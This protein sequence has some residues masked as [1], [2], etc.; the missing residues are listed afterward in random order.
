VLAYAG[1]T[2]SRFLQEATISR[3]EQPPRIAAGSESI[4]RQGAQLSNV[5]AA[6]KS[7]VTK[8]EYYRAMAVL[9][10]SH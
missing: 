9:L 6:M 2:T 8:L 10:G 7:A 1:R 5:N 4:R 3:I